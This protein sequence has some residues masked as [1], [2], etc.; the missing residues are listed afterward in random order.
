MNLAQHNK[1]RAYYRTDRAIANEELLMPEACEL[2][3]SNHNIMPHHWKGYGHPLDIWFICRSCNNILRGRHDG[4][5]SKDAILKVFKDYYPTH[6]VARLLD[7]RTGQITWRIGKGIFPG[8]KKLSEF[9]PADESVKHD[10]WF[11]P[12]SLFEVR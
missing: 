3:G 5:I 9:F 4:M 12:K 1:Q 10:P 11:I 8:A 2:C 6:I 7:L